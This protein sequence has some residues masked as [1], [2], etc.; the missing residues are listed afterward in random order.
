M[1]KK[2]IVNVIKARIGTLNEATSYP[3]V[4]DSNKAP[5]IEV[6]FGS[7]NRAATRIKG[8]SPQRETGLFTVNCHIEQQATGGDDSAND[9]A[10]RVSDLFPAGLQ[11]TFTGGRVT[12]LDPPDIRAGVP[13]D[14][15]WY[16]P[17]IITYA[18]S[19]T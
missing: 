5:F 7:S 9:L 4:T 10:D 2:D 3:N 11:I 8:G 14:V 13:T 18:A 6:V 17:V 16:V 15:D 12:I 19:P 1:N